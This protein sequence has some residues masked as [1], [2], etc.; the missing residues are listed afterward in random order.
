[1]H[2]TDRPEVGARSRA[3]MDC[4]GDD[5]RGSLGFGHTR[6]RHCAENDGNREHFLQKHALSS[7][8]TCAGA[9]DAGCNRFVGTISIKEESVQVSQVVSTRRLCLNPVQAQEDA[10]LRSLETITRA[11]I[12]DTGHLVMRN[13]REVVLEATALAEQP[14]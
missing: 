9:R 6:K 13:D 10:L 8:S 12:D 3:K 5:R 4:A 14:R 1:M 11:D 7:N 2:A